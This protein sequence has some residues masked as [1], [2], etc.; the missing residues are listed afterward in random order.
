MTRPTSIR[1]NADMP[2]DT[3]SPGAPAQPKVILCVAN[4]DPHVVANQLIAMYLR[5]RGFDVINLGACTPID[6]IMAACQRHPEALAVLIG[7]LNGHAVEDLRGL[8]VQKRN[9]QVRMPVFVGGNLS[10]GSVKT[11]RANAMLLADG[12]DRIVT[13]V[14]QLPGILHAL[15]PTD[16]S[17]AA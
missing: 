9:F 11:D 3:S 7:S 4:S 1:R 8:A 15:I 12:V 17:H 14:D 2:G 6:E 10:V 13:D 5:D 16:A